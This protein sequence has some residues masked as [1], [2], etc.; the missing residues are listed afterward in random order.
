[1]ASE[2]EA[3]PQEVLGDEEPRY[4][5]RQKPLEIRR[6]KFGKRTWPA[7]RRAFVVGAVVI[8]SGFLIYEV[9]A[10]MLYSPRVTLAGTDQ[11]EIIGNRYVARQS[12]TERFAADV[13][14][15]IIRLPLDDR[16]KSLETIPWIDHAIVSR[17]WPN[18]IRV[19]FVERTPVAFL[20][21]TNDLALIDAHGVVLERPIEGNFQF[22]VVSG[23]P[24]NMPAPQRDI[25]MGLYT[26]LLHD[27][28]SVKPGAPDNVSEVDLADATD[29]RV[30]LAGLGNSGL[31]NLNDQGP[32][33]VHFG[34]KDFDS[35]FGVLLDN[36]EQW[37]ASAGRLDSV[38]L[39][40]SKQVVLNPET[41]IAASHTP[42]SPVHISPKPAQSNAR[43][44]SPRR[45]PARTH[46]ARKAH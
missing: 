6:R 43:P 8:A 42:A 16:R 12:I 36:I 25:R 30:T 10:F 44:S 34:N 13:G 40:F 45:A 1:M 29:V 37:R 7:Y 26:Q 4:L 2:P 18:R 9:G 24:D 14:H 39:R 32:L 38:D 15:S 27:L 41:T 20:R 17:I 3:V 19:E 5:R 22:P 35:K 23:I 33:L 28:N 46:V 11:I 21:N 31:A